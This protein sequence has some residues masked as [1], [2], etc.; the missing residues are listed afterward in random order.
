VTIYDIAKACGVSIA[1][2]SRVLNNS[3]KVSEKTRQKVLAVIQEENYSPNPFARGL[4]LDS[5]KMIGLLCT[6]VSDAF[7]AKAVSLVEHEL[8]QRGLDMMLVCTGNDLNEKKKYIQFLLK[9]HVDA[10]ILIGSPFREDGDNSHVAEAAHE[11]PII[12]INSLLEL[13]NVY[14]VLC[15]EASG[16]ELAVRRLADNGCRNILYLYDNLTYSGQ[17]KIRGYREGLEAAGLQKQDKFL[18]QVSKDLISAQQMVQR[19]LKQQLPFSAIIGS[20]DIIAIGAQKALSA[21][22]IEIPVIGCNNSV[23]AE[24]ATPSLTS[25]DNRLDILCPAA[26]DVLTKILDNGPQAAPSQTVFP[27]I[28]Q[29]RESFKE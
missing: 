19:L 27:A 1:T 16:I 18:C 11:V 13:P 26:V 5:M 2:V 21:A 24:C 17:Q 29:Y 14:S 15:D 25:I 28:I 23:L 4:G 12:A 7:Y 10:I 3:E 20:E 6:D 9:K 8:K 22:G